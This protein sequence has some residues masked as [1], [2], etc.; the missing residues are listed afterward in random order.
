MQLKVPIH[1]YVSSMFCS[2]LGIYMKISSSK[3]NFLQI[4]LFGQ[5]L[6]QYLF[7]IIISVVTFG[8]KTRGGEWCCFLYS[9][10]LFSPNV[11]QSIL[12]PFLVGF[13]AALF[14]IA[15][16]GIDDCSLGS[17]LTSVRNFKFN[18]K[19]LC[20]KSISTLLLSKK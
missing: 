11:L 13:V 12:L 19:L 5:N 2:K 20:M 16:A 7:A 4:L 8:S 18:D 9:L 14:C 10:C 3:L 6:V 1:S 15:T 17:P